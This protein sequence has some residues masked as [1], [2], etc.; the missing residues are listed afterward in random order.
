M[1][2]SAVLL[3]QDP[4]AD[5]P[6]FAGRHPRPEGAV[7]THSSETGTSIYTLHAKSCDN[8]LAVINLALLAIVELYIHLHIYFE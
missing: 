7:H 3:H 2:Q 8:S 6:V 4:V 1:L 5:V